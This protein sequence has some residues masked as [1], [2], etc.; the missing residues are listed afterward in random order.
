[1]NEANGA[2][3]KDDKEPKVVKKLDLDNMGLRKWGFYYAPK[4]CADKYCEI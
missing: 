3:A 2:K 4:K 1:M